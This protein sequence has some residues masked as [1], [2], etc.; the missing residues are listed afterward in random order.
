MLPWD[1]VRLRLD[2]RQVVAQ[3]HELKRDK[4]LCP[5]HTEKTPSCHIY[6]DHFYCFGC[7]K[8]GDVFDWV[9]HVRGISPYEALVQLAPTV[10]VELNA[11]E[12]QR[13]FNRYQQLEAAAHQWHA[14]LWENNA[15]LEYL[16]SRGISDDALKA[17]HVGVF[18]TGQIV[19][20]VTDRY[21]HHIGWQFHN[22][23]DDLRRAAAYRL[24]RG[25]SPEDGPKY[26]T[27]ATEY[28]KRSEAVWGLAQ[29]RLRYDGKL[30]L[31]EGPYDAISLW[32]CGVAAVAHMGFLGVSQ[33]AAILHIF[34]D[35]HIILC[36]DTTGEGI[37][38]AHRNAAVLRKEYSGPV[39]VLV[40]REKDANESLVAG[41][42]KEQ[43]SSVMPLELWQ[44]RSLL[45][46]PR[47][48]AERSLRHVY[49][50]ASPALRGQIEQIVAEAWKIEP[51][52]ARQ[53]LTA[54]GRSSLPVYSV[55]DAW[56]SLE[57][58]VDS[59]ATRAP[60]SL[61]FPV[62]DEHIDLIPGKIMHIV[63]RAGIGK[64]AL[65]VQLVLN[66]LGTASPPG[67]VVVGFEPSPA[68]IILRAAINIAARAGY[69]EKD[70]CTTPARVLSKLRENEEAWTVTHDLVADM[71]R[72]NVYFLHG[73][74]TVQE[75][76]AAVRQI[77]VD[78]IGRKVDFVFVDYLELARSQQ[79]ESFMHMMEVIKDAQTMAGV[80][81]TF[82][83]VLR[84]VARHRASSRIADIGEAGAMFG[85]EAQT[86]YE[87]T[88]RRRYP[89]P[90]QPLEIVAKI[91][92]NRYG[93]EWPLAPAQSMLYTPAVY[94]VEPGPLPVGVELEAQYIIEDQRLERQARGLAEGRR[95]DYAV[96]NKDGSAS[97]GPAT[98]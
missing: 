98:P 68:D 76:E 93:E 87:V 75:V 72:T 84:Q 56:Q 23:N 97:R 45:E 80:L 46:R 82:V 22:W 3:S 71:M 47:E 40:L 2:L 34:K 1:E 31:V 65:M 25:K 60:Y 70:V 36:P 85:G 53:F 95:N 63:G 9:A 20:P 50:S 77:E 69:V 86:D 88:L 29:A 73:P 58:I 54:R 12:A 42:L 59:F 35:P 39:S 14:A 13:R 52:V 79:K 6:Q 83:V 38:K 43:I 28:F 21:G 8:S 78:H 91:T 24:S 17:Y 7:G 81:N 11:E 18:R 94:W 49:A 90:G 19:L 32:Q 57:A 96:S 74:T 64:T 16:R 26:E 92:K 33:V 48:E 51:V 61:G 44:T 37:E 27:K 66:L 55:D 67:I 89:K 15:V 30:Y 10:G 4:V 5:F 41:T 62:L